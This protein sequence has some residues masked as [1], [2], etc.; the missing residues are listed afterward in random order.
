MVERRSVDPELLKEE[1][2]LL[3]LGQHHG[4][5]TPLLDWTGSYLVALFFAFGG[6]KGK[7]LKKEQNVRVWQLDQV[8]LRQASIDFQKGEVDKA[9]R[10]GSDD[11]LHK[12]F[13]RSQRGVRVIETRSWANSRQVAQD[14]ISRGR[15]FG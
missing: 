10:G 8:K 2:Q 12:R 11:L 5:P 4:L 15:E 1:D 7:K 9:D 14:G 3:A 6:W 13:Q